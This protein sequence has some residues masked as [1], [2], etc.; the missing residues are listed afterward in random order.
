VDYEKTLAQLTDWALKNESVRAMVLTGSGGA[1]DA[2]CL[3]DRDIEIYCT[4]VDGLLADE[5]WWMGLG[6]VLVVERLENPGRHPTRLV[7]YVGGKLDFNLLRAERLGDQVY[8]RPFQVL[9]DKDGTAP[10]EVTPSTWAPPDASKFDESVNWAYA[11]ALMC[12][13]AVVRGELW[14]AK[15][16]DNDLKGQLLEMI[17]WDHRTRYGPDFDTRYL[18]TRMNDWMD[19]DVRHALHT[20]WGHFDAIDAEHA[21]RSSLDL[22]VVLAKRTASNLGLPDFDPDALRAELETILSQRITE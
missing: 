12:A 18:G 11:A 15:I 20:C 2:H 22:Y 1:R 4:D 8:D 10:S 5:S 3:S 19:A 9:V 6:Q 14:S 17:E 21:L 16:R 13:K 7:Y